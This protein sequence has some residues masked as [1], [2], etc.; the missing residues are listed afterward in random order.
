MHYPK[1][2]ISMLLLS[3]MVFVA[4]TASIQL[5]LGNVQ[6]LSIFPVL[7]M[8]LLGDSIVSVQ[9]HKKMGEAFTIIFVTIALGL[10]GFALATFQGMR[11]TLILYPEVILLLIPINILMGRYFGLRLSELFRFR[12]FSSYGSE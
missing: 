2:S 1:R 11:N 12:S 5:G 4:L 10:F 6:E 3:I 9:L 7:I 8:T